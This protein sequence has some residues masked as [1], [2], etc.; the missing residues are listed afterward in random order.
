MKKHFLLNVVVVF[1]LLL[2]LLSPAFVNAE[3]T[4]EDAGV[5]LTKVV[6]TEEGVSL[7]WETHSNNEVTGENESFSL[8]KDGVSEEIS[9]ELL[10]E[11][12]AEGTHVYTYLDEVAPSGH[13]IE[14]SIAWNSNDTI[15]TSPAITITLEAP[16][17][18]QENGDS[19]VEEVDSNV[20]EVDSNVE[21]E[22]EPV[23]KKDASIEESIK[24]DFMEEPFL[25]IEKMYVNDSGFNVLWYGY[26]SEN[27][28]SLA[29]Y[30]LY[31]DGNLIESGSSRR[32][33]DYTFNNLTANTTYEVTVKALTSSNV[34][35]LENSLEITTLPAP[36]GE[37]AV[38]ADVNL[39]QAIKDHY[40]ISRDLYE[41]DVVNLTE[42]YAADMN[43]TSLEGLEKAVNLEV[44][45]LYFNNISDV[46]PLANLTKLYDLDLEGNNITDI[47]PLSNLTNLYILW[48]AGNPVSDIQHLEKLTNIEYLYLN[49]T[50]ISN[51]DVLLK[52]THLTSVTLL[53]TNLDLSEG[54][55]VW[56]IL[57]V[58]QDA[59]VYV[60]LFDE[61]F[62]PYF[63]LWT[64]GTSEESIF[65]SWWYSFENEEDLYHEYQYKVYVDGT[66]YEETIENY[67]LVTNLKAD[68]EYDILVEMYNQ[69]GEFVDEAFTLARTLPLP[70]GDI[71]TIADAGLDEAIR[72][73][74]HLPDRVIYQSDMDRLYYL[75]ASHMQ[76][77]DISGLEYAYNLESLDLQGNMI[78]SLTPLK[79]LQYLGHLS[80]ADNALTNIDA[81]KDMY[82]FSL[83]ISGNPITD[84]SVLDTLSDL[85]Y[86][87]LHHTA[88]SDL[89][90]LLT[91]DYLMEVSLFGI[92][93]LTFEEGT[94]ELA[95]VDELIAR[96]VVVYLDEDDYYGSSLI[97]INVLDVT[98]N[99]IE[100]DWTYEGEEEIAYYEIMVD[101]EWVDTVGEGYY[102]FTDLHSDTSYDIA[103]AAF[104][105]EGNWLDLNEITVSTLPLEA[106]EEDENPAPVEEDKE[107]TPVGKP[108]DDKNTDGTKK[109]KDTKTSTDKKAEG[110]KL[111]VTATNT[112]NYI[113]VGFALLL[114]GFGA[115]LFARRTRVI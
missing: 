65:L 27:D 90:V 32:F 64:E 62:F 13:S 106:D 105:A 8:V 3:G 108:V 100:I 18:N 25:A 43:I 68:T 49:D 4:A 47:T 15:F 93:G 29:K 10:E 95:I 51:I 48:L 24:D 6:Q 37:K 30:E 55:S 111:P 73:S 70:T 114:V 31:L 103:I 33:M 109:E 69:D 16:A 28:R 92:E 83:D 110:N 81:L 45:A 21:E 59:G 23:T 96:G 56:N 14:Y 36:T 52:L 41:S 53:G 19:N 79:N 85:E 54:S 76:I 39:A 87:Y 74:L 40:G 78:E 20:E 89:S 72:Q 63:D 84:I 5:L 67:L 104:D 12:S 44:L 86:L 77:S 11:Q 80:I 9:P 112:M 97:D 58:W 82:L 60:D 17:S 42:L 107:E 66:L 57:N 61:E 34:L 98:D 101:Q 38:F 88:V 22:K 1:T 99:S 115:L 35:L 50:N 71:I 75:Y 7:V 94:P 113:L 102:L 46:S 26:I 2:S 91:L